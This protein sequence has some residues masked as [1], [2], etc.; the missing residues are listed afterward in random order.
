[1]PLNCYRN[2]NSS[3]QPADEVVKK[4]GS[5]RLNKAF[6]T[7]EV[8]SGT[9]IGCLRLVLQVYTL[10]SLALPN[11]IPVILYGHKLQHR[12]GEWCRGQLPLVSPEVH[13]AAT[14]PFRLL[15]LTGQWSQL[16]VSK[17]KTRATTISG[18]LLHGMTRD[19]PFCQ[20]PIS[21]TPLSVLRVKP[22]IWATLPN[23]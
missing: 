2:A 10:R 11:L 23:T 22:L 5:D 7:T 18:V 3:R 19:P 21:P 16:Y 14:T 6:L 12:K 8:V 15:L 1:V 13:L 17:E 4:S 20:H 9:Q